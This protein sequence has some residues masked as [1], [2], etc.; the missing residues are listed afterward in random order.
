[1]LLRN[2]S[3]FDKIKNDHIDENRFIG[4]PCELPVVFNKAEPATV[5]RLPPAFILT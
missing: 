5:Y 4:G 2:L 3:F 1:M